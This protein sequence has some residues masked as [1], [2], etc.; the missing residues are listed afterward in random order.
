M[1]GTE[2]IEERVSVEN[3]FK[4]AASSIQKNKNL[5]LSNDDDTK[6]KDFLSK[7]EFFAKLEV[8]SSVVKLSQAYNCLENPWITSDE[9]QS[10]LE[11][12]P[13][14]NISRRFLGLHL[15]TELLSLGDLTNDS[16]I[17]L[18]Q[19][20]QTGLRNDE[21]DYEASYLSK[22]PL[23]EKSLKTSLQTP[24]KKLIGNLLK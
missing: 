2:S 23:L 4:S 11:E 21:K 19:A 1:S 7:A 20:L 22:L 6:E 5:F 16:S 9:C 17:S 13:I 3:S 10:I 8:P 18:L 12:L 15:L 24:F 14:K